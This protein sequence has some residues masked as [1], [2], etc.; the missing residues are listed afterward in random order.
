MVVMGRR[1]TFRTVTYS[2][3]MLS[4]T[5]QVSRFIPT[6]TFQVERR[7]SREGNVRL[8]RITPD[9]LERTLTIGSPSPEPPPG[10]YII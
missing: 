6:L 5:E 1:Y 3:L 7:T 10:F 9:A 4:H 2:T 8:Y